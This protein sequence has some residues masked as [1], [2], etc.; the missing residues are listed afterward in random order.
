MRELSIL[1][2]HRW[3]KPQPTTLQYLK[4]V[5]TATEKIITGELT[6]R[7]ETVIFRG[8]TIPYLSADYGQVYSYCY[9]PNRV[10]T[11]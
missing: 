5:V 9:D 2:G 10:R 11:H 6:G 7:E 3:Q 8:E 4:D 1:V